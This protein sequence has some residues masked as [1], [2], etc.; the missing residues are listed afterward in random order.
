MRPAL[1][2]IAG[3]ATVAAPVPRPFERRD[4][5]PYSRGSSGDHK[6]AIQDHPMRT[7]TVVI[8]KLAIQ[9]HAHPGNSIPVKQN[10]H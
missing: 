1:A 8:I 3:S 5:D 9:E 6:S 7:T 10:K 2:T 4:V